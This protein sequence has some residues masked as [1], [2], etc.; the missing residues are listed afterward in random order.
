M[1]TTKELKAHEAALKVANA[2]AE[3]KQLQENSNDVNNHLDQK[4]SEKQ[5]FL[6]HRSRV[7]HVDNAARQVGIDND[8]PIWTRKQCHVQLL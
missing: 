1:G 4:I 2:K 6:Q 3:A 8:V 7:C 5:T